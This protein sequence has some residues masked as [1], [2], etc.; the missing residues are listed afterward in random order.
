[1]R[2][3]E[4]F[5]NNSATN[6]TAITKN[7]TGT[8]KLSGATL[9]RAVTVTQATDHHKQRG[10]WNWNQEY[11]AQQRDRWH[12]ATFPRWQHWDITLP[13]TF[14]YATSVNTTPSAGAFVNVAGNNT[15]QGTINPTS[16]GGDT[17]IVV[18]AVP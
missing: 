16:G 13:S 14:T 15:I 7:G 8:W 6:T 3:L 4:L 9:S 11:C 10:T 12:S 18:T 2:S 5:R 17:G 1:V